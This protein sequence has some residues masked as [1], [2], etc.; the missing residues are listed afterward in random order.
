MARTIPVF[1]IFDYN[2]T[3][4]FYV[5]WLGFK[6]NWE[7]K[8]ANA[9]VYME[10]SK[11]DIILHLSE[12]YGDSTPGSRVFIDNFPDIKEYHQNLIAKK[13]KYMNPGIEKA[14]W[15]VNT[16]CMEVIDPFGNRITFTSKEE[17]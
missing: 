1:R 15:D 16:I 11:G 8:T 14:S 4:E 5:D 6:I 2:K 17:E 7:D 13:Y 10:I 9:P 3:I 12:H